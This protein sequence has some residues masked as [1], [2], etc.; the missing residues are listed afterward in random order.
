MPSAPGG[1]G[2][3]RRTNRFGWMRVALASGLTVAG[4][5]VLVTRGESVSAVW[6]ALLAA[7]A[8]LVGSLIIAAPW[9]LRLWGDLGD[10]RAARARAPSVPTSPPTCT[11]RCCRP[12]PSSS[13]GRR[14]RRGRPPG[15]R[16]GARAAAWLYDGA[17]RAPGRPSPLRVTEVAPR[18][19]TPR[20]GRS[21]V[22]VTGD[23][24]APTPHARRCSQAMREALVNAVRHGGPPV[25]VYVE[26]GPSAVE[27]FVRDHGDGFDL[28][29][30]PRRPVG[31]RESIIG[32]MERHGRHGAGAP[33][34]ATAPRSSCGCHRSKETRRPAA[35]PP[36]PATP[37]RVVL[38]DDHRMFRT[39]VRAELTRPGRRA[40][41]R[42]RSS[43]RRPTS[44]RP[45]R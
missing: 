29:E 8:V 43:G 16:P 18:S 35:T 10:E 44:T 26:V 14:L 42:A 17:D 3:D 22:V 1:S 27:A 38:V 4:I 33:P 31:V 6:D 32:R 21:T 20:R 37:V 28:D 9:W 2:P 15:P 25:S 13:A 45:S 30:V 24:A 12:S 36:T 11:T 34:R 23:R 7:V 19:R 41:R 40:C 39:G 5:L